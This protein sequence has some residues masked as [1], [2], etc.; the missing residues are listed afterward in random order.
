[1]FAILPVGVR[2][3]ELKDPSQFISRGYELAEGIVQHKGISPI[4]QSEM[5]VLRKTK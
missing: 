2:K 5:C 1:M 4:F 3:A